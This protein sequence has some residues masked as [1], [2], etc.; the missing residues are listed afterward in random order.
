[1]FDNVSIKAQT[2]MVIYHASGVSFSNGS[3]I[4]PSSGPAVT[5][6]DATVSGITT[7]AF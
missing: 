6:F 3:S 1:M 7:T 5:V 2:G 4:A